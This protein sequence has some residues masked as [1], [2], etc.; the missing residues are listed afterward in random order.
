MTERPHEPPYGA[1]YEPH[2]ACP[3]D[4]QVRRL[5]AAAAEPDGPQHA[6]PGPE[7]TA[8]ARRGLY[9]RRAALAAAVAAVV[10]GVSFAV[11]AAVDRIRD[12]S[13]AEVASADCVSETA[14]TV[15]SYEGR[16]YLP[17]RVTVLTGKRIPI[18][19]GVTQGFGFRVRAGVNLSGEPVPPG[20]LTVW[21]P[22]HPGTLPGGE[23]L[24]LLLRPAKRQG[25]KGERLFDVASPHAYAVTGD[26]RVT[27]PCGGSVP[28]ERLRAAVT[29]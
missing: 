28:M 24:V 9:R 8:R 12:D 1:A 19:D 25:T 17:L 5:L 16:G 11:P 10:A 4:E 15:R 14:R 13:S 23:D 20:T 26:D 6:A 22:L 7:F 2:G 29:A 18:D 27:L 3:E 21:N